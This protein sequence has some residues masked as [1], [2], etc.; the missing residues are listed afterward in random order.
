MTTYSL[1]VAKLLTLG[2]P[3]TFDSD[4][5]L[6]YRSL[7]LDETYIPDLIRL[8]TDTELCLLKQDTPEIWGPVHAWRALGQ[9]QAVAAVEPLLSL[10]ELLQDDEW[11]IEELPL[12]LAMIG[13]PAVA[14]L[15]AYLEQTEHGEWPRIHVAQSLVNI[16][17]HHTEVRVD[18][19]AVLAG[20]LRRYED[21]G[22]ELNA[23]LISYLM[24]LS[25][26]ECLPIMREAFE[27]DAVNLDI[28]GD[29][30]DVEIEL[31]VRTERTN[32]KPA[33]P[34]LF[35]AG[36]ESVGFAQEQDDTARKLKA[37][38]KAKRKMEK[39]SRKKSRKKRK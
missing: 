22:T 39:Q 17:Q 5:W 30:E 31:G 34:G 36:E 2:K 27:A 16:A 28:V 10:F 25:A 24:D 35:P 11:V 20:Q 33:F 23:F 19:V 14:P 1:P 29:L 26:S 18:C 4:A 7:G 9:F 3:E 32:P 12:M 6:D 15:S 13:P 8:A 21:N 38:V 37:K